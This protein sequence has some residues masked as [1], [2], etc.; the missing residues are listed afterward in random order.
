LIIRVN[1]SLHTEIL[2]VAAL[3]T[4]QEDKLP[5]AADDAGKA[6]EFWF[7]N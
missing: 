6:T 2:L 3:A 7:M 5:T 1:N 4:N